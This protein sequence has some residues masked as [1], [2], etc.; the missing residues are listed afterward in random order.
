MLLSVAGDPVSTVWSVLGV[1]GVLLLV[2]LVVVGWFVSGLVSLVGGVLWVALA[3]RSWVGS[4]WCMAQ[5]CHGI[6]QLQSHCL[7]ARLRSQLL[8]HNRLCRRSWWMVV[9]GRVWVHL[10]QVKA[11]LMHWGGTGGGAAL[12]AWLRWVLGGV[13][14]YGL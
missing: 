9:V 2:P 7:A 11:A 1:V 10:G 12:L 4:C 3:A 5:V 14:W 6:L 8:H 13:G